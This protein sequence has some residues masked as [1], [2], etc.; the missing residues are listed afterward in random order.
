MECSKQIRRAAGM[1][2][3]VKALLVVGIPVTGLMIALV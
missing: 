3:L 1:A 2:I